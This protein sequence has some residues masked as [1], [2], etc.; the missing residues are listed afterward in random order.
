MIFVWVFP[1]L[2]YFRV[3][4]TLGVTIVTNVVLYCSLV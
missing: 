4:A 1:F 2:Y 3:C